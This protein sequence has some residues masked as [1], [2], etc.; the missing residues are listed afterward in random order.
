MC[1]LAG[2]ISRTAPVEERMILQATT[3]LRHRGP[4]AEGT[5]INEGRNIALGHRRLS[6]IDLSEAAAQ[7]MSF[8]GRYH[9]IHNGE[10]YNH[11]ELRKELQ[12]KNY[13]FHSRSDT[14]VILAAFD[15]WGVD[16]MQRLEGMFAFI[17]WDEEEQKLFAA[18]DRFGE[19]PLFYHYHQD[20]LL[21]ASEQKSLWQMGAGK[22]VNPRM[23]YN[24]LTI[25]Y[26]SNPSDPG[27]TFFE[28]V[29][30]LPAASYLEY[31]LSNHELS[32]SRYWQIFP[33]VDQSISEQEAISR[34]SSLFA[35]SISKR[36]RSDVPV[37][38]SLSGGIDSSSIVLFC[39]GHTY[40]HACFTA[41]FPGFEKNE[42]EHARSIA[43][44]FGLQHHVVE[45]RKE[46]I[47]PL[48]EKTMQHQEEPFGSGS[49]LAQFKVY[50]AAKLSG[51]TVLLDGQGA[52]EVLA[53]YHR[54]YRWYWQELFRAKQLGKS[55]ELKK[56]MDLGVSERFT[57]R[58][59][60]AALWPEF[61]GG[62]Q[63]GIKIRQ[64]FRNPDLDREF[65]F[66]NKQSLYYSLPTSFDLNGALYFNTF[67]QGLGELLRLADRNSMAHATEVRLPFLDHKLVEFLF[68]LP[69]AFKIKDGWTKWMLR[70]T[71]DGRLPASIT[72]RKD[73]V[74]FE[75][76]QKEWMQTPDVQQA[77]LGAK[78]KL[79][80][81]GVL[82][83]GAVKKLKPHT[84][85]AAQT[86]D[87]KYWSASYLFD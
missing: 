55:G 15:A 46:E 3:C 71:V 23:L 40:S 5:W 31:S 34:F 86:Q 6:I 76:P 78:K 8:K 47:V 49:V 37:G 77:I 45:V 83:Q 65:A 58:H 14:E 7:P 70:K 84:A 42:L 80:D 72:W 63:Q 43:G 69:P 16:C 1:G 12:A 39:D 25:G 73:K 60:V 21:L 64:A 56:A 66:S 18:R 62:I 59:R 57:F 22:K 11:I 48:M 44:Q 28:Q 35:D 26:T 51:I 75:P 53:G 38:T 68:T 74:G 52:D 30:Q 32:V 2:M 61:S 79:A 17:I 81:L 33:S 19:K 85:Y 13:H 50:E 82:N 41:A 10:I 67:V 20:G 54:Y 24:F 29:Q 87:W 36:L 9:I 27:E 4:S